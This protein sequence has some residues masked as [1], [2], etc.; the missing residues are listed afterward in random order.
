MGK[1]TLE[2][3]VDEVIMLQEISGD[4]DC[5]SEWQAGIAASLHR[6]AMEAY[7]KPKISKEDYEHYRAKIM[8]NHCLFLPKD[9]IVQKELREMAE[10]AL[11][12][13]YRMGGDE[14]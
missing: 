14:E 6:K 4:M 3:T 10:Q 9:A 5:C 1:I 8:E 11:R 7:R 13:Y 2:L 12:F